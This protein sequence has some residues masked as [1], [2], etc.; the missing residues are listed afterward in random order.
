[1]LFVFTLFFFFLGWALANF[2]GL[3]VCFWGCFFVFGVVL[4][5]FFP[6]GLVFFLVLGPGEYSGGG[7]FLLMVFFISMWSWL[8]WGAMLA[9]TIRG[10]RVLLAA[11]SWFCFG[12]GSN[13]ETSV[14]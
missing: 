6:E 8:G 12:K 2:L 3:F 5:F 9:R 10:V 7:T 14:V 1:M 11:W 4:G 13:P